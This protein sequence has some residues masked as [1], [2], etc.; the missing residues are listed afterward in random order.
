MA[1]LLLQSGSSL[2][3]GMRDAVVKEFFPVSTRLSHLGALQRGGGGA[4]VPVVSLYDFSE[5]RSE[6]DGNPAGA[7]FSRRTSRHL[8]C[9]GAGLSGGRLLSLEGRRSVEKEKVLCNAAASS[10]SSSGA[11]ADF[12][13]VTFLGRAFLQK[14]VQFVC[15]A[16]AT[17]LL[18]SANKVLY[19]MALV[20]L[21]AYPL[22][23]AQ[24]NTITYVLA[25]SSILLMRYR[26]GIVTKEML[27]IPKGKFVLIG[28]LDS[29]GLAMGM[30]SAAFL[31]GALVP[32]LAQVFL[33]WQLVLS[34]TILRKRYSF[35]QIGGCLLVIAGVVTVVSSGS[36][37]A[38]AGSLQ[39]SGYIRPLG[40]VVSTLFYAA[41]A[42]LK[43]SVFR[44]G[45]DLKGGNLDLFVVNTC[46]SFFQTIFCSMIIPVVFTLRGVPFY[47]IPHSLKEG[48]AC[49]VNFGGK[50][51][52]CEGAP[53]VPLLYVVVNMLFNICSLNLLKNYSAIVSS[54]CVTLSIPLSIWAFTLPWPYLGVPPPLPPGFFLGATV[55]VAGLAIYGLSKPPKDNNRRE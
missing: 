51:S 50:V 45:K 8:M 18:A 39:Q 30:V 16:V 40:M 32:V 33:V 28:A 41:A 23:L 36:G 12:D 7:C 43:E 26:A 6:E 49:F 22:F 46:G 20:P 14:D 2:Q 47:Q 52:G 17:V 3:L 13:S 11:H 54:L 53:W 25:Y 42:I 44:S 37:D 55:L 24:F 10:G 34:S 31:P 29:L 21:K 4:R 27:A 9:K 5:V 19:R 35:A 38:V 48:Y 15:A 1:G